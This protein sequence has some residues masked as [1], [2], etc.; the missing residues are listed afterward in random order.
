MLADAEPR[1]CQNKASRL[2]WRIA[3]P[4]AAATSAAGWCPISSTS[5]RPD[6]GGVVLKAADKWYPFPPT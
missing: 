4:L 1:T 3:G 6:H 2:A 5:A